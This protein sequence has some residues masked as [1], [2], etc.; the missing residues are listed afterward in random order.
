MTT[1]TNIDACIAKLESVITNTG[2]ATYATVKT[3]ILQMAV[4]AL[5]QQQKQID[6][7]TPIA[8]LHA[9]R[10]PG[11]SASSAEYVVEVSAE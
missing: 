2:G 9:L 7:M 1:L 8:M 5:R 10:N 3:A 6:D 11:E 4:R